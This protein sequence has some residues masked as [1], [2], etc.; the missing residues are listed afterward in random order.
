MASLQFLALEQY[1]KSNQYDETNPVMK[2]VIF[3]VTS[4]VEELDEELLEINDLIKQKEIEFTKKCEFKTIFMNMTIYDKNLTLISNFLFDEFTVNRLDTVLHA[5]WKEYFHGL[6]DLVV[7]TANADKAQLLINI[8]ENLKYFDILDEPVMLNPNDKLYPT[9]QYC[10]DMFKTLKKIQTSMMIPDFHLI[11]K[12]T[13]KINQQIRTEIMKL[14]KLRK[15]K[16]LIRQKYL[17]VLRWA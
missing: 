3:D 16:K 5:E 2:N 17:T 1:M 10:R 15:Q 13:I 8:H 4:T 6:Y 11:I 14:K 7:I 12:K 9:V